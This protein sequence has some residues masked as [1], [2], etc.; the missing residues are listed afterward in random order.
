[1][2]SSTE[3]DFAYR[4]AILGLGLMGGSLALALRHRCQRLSAVDRDPETLALARQQGLVDA[5]SDHPEEILPQADAVILA[6]PVKTILEFIPR[7]PSLIPDNDRQV[8]VLDLGST[9]VQICRAFEELPARFDP[10]GGHPMCGKETSGLANAEAGLYQGAAFAFTALPRTTQRARAFAAQLARVV[11]AR[12]L[13]L[14]PATHDRWVA[15]TSHLPYLASC[16]LSSATPLEAAPLVGPGFRDAARLAESP[17]HV[18][19]DILETNREH[20]LP[21]VKRLQRQLELLEGDLASGDFESL[22]TRL[23]KSA[24]QR[25]ILARRENNPQDRRLD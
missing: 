5:L 9:K 15:A 13:W 10:L 23:E 19:L 18:M 22:K 17:A 14:D 3:P 24:T 6:T 21:A 7:M 4:I 16:A 12:E 2:E 20:L 11:G 25:E 8:I 1:M